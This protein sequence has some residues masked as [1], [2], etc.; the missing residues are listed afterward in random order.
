MDDNTSVSPTTTTS[1]TLTASATGCT[2]VTATVIVTVEESTAC[3]VIDSFS[4]SPTT[5]TSGLSS[6]LRW[7]TTGAT[8]VT[9]SGVS[10]TLAVDGNT[11]V[12][13]TTTTNYTLTASATGCTDVTA[14]VSVTVTTTTPPSTPVVPTATLTANPATIDEGVSSTLTWATT[15]AVGATI[16]P[17][18][19]TVSPAATGEVVRMHM[20]AYDVPFGE[21]LYYEGQSEPLEAGS[22]AVIED[23]GE[24]II[25]IWWRRDSSQFDIGITETAGGTASSYWGAGLPGASKSIFI[26]GHDSGATPGIE[27]SFDDFVSAGTNGVRFS[28]TDLT[29]RG[30]L[31]GIWS[32]DRFTMIIADA[33]ALSLNAPPSEGGSVRVSPTETT[34]YTLTARGPAGIVTDSASITVNPAGPMIDT[35]TATSTTITEGESTTLEW[36]TSGATTVT[37]PGTSGT[38]TVDGSVNVSPT[39]TTIYTLTASDDDAAT[40]D[41]TAT[42]TVTVNPA[43]PMIDTFT[44]TSTT[45][46]E[47]ESTTLEWTTTGATTVTIPGTS[48]TLTVDGSVNV[49]PTETTIYTLTASD[50]DAATADATASVTITVLPPDPVI[51]SF[52]ASDTTI[53][54]GDSTMLEWETTN[55]TS[56]SIPGTSGTLAVDGSTSVSPTTTTTYRLTASGASGTTADTA[57]VAVIVLHPPPR[58]ACPSIPTRSSTRGTR[59]R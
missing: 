37:I 6:T 47:G 38:L 35:F 24:S 13:P 54:E 19:G 58:R 29:R 36:T 52:S 11:S 56:V 46:T 17:D 34:S 22:D 14:S 51:D 31:N 10:G 32:P 55:A 59:P 20:E 2:D 9:I 43:G 12:S 48:G 53:T 5:I 1:Y 23:L 50:D 49:S 3:P 18:L 7:T 33:G 27:I 28:I 8:T 25:R 40:A 4:A 16:E 45:I 21:D 42:V 26:Y 39:E 44:A 15:D 41:A 30:F 57:T